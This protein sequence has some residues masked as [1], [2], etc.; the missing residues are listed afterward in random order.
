MLVNYSRHATFAQAVS[1]TFDGEHPCRLCH[2]IQGGKA[3]EREQ[4]KDGGEPG[5]ELKLA[6][7]PVPCLL[8][9]PPIPGVPAEPGALLVSREAPPPSPPPRLA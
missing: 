2:A 1:M 3:K 9:H 6:L 7:P 8:S 4:K 5:K